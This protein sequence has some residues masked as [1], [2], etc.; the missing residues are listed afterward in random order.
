MQARQPEIFDDRYEL[1]ELLGGGQTTSVHRAR[2]LADG[3]EVALKILDPTLTT[4]PQALGRFRREIEAG[5]LLKH[6]TLIRLLD[7]GVT[8]EGACYMVVELLSGDTLRQLLDRERR[9]PPGRVQRIATQ[10]TNGLVEAHGHAIIHRDLKPDNIFVGAGDQVKV[11]DFGLVR[12]TDADPNDR[13]LTRRG[14]SLGSIQYLAPEAVDATRADAR[15]DLYSL[16]II[17]Y[18][19]LTGEHPIPATNIVNFLHMHRTHVPTSLHGH[20]SAPDCPPAL[21][22][23]VMSL[24][25]KDPADRPQSARAVLATLVADQD[26]F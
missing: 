22:S 26:F 18:E 24:L 15:S 9:L 7:T 17:L 13:R 8:P 12:F 6:P 4:N 3:Q 2:R 16:G 19:C 14:M 11:I 5:R 25:S 10:L 23:L 1:L 21:A 20:P